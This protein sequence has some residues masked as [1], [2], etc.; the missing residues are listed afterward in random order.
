EAARARGSKLPLLVRFADILGD[1]LAR[2]RGAFAGAMRDWDYAGGY[3]AVYPVQVNQEKGV[4]SELASG[5][6]GGFGLEAGSKPEL[7][8]VLALA[9][10]GS[11]VICNGYKD[12]EYLRLALIGRKLG[13]RVF[14]VIEK[15][16][17][18]APAIEEAK[19]LEVEPLFGVRM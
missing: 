16:S 19:A 13:L 3:S 1:R 11:I 10:P 4:V 15:P 6:G 7:M 2:L 18:L 8:A 17:E 14:I 12:R 5:G 9:H